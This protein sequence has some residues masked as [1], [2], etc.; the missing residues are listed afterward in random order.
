VR[1]DEFID[2]VGE[3]AGA[4]TTEAVTASNAVL[5]ALGERIGLR[6]AADTASQLPSELQE[7]LLDPDRSR[8]G[9]FGA[10]EFVERVGERAG[11]EEK[12]A[13]DRT[14]AVFVALSEAVSEGE[15]LDWQPGL[16]TD[17]VDLA[18]RPAETGQNP[19]TT[20]PDSPARQG[21][22]IGGQEFIHRVAE[23]A[24]LDDQNAARATD[25]VLETLGERIAAGEGQDLATQLPEPAAA[26]LTRAGGDAQA[27]P[28]AEFVRRIAER[29]GTL[30]VVAREHAR[31]VLTTVREAVTVDEWQDAVEQ[32][33]REYEELLL[34]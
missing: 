24:G 19:R 10:A 11:L 29:E 28:A 15:L 13:L 14:R 20:P 25:V 30:D 22:V 8:S 3:L 33:P 1:Y 32:L 21:P 23:R 5:R 4:S 34:T 7:P 27:M 12:D 18:A 16:Q 26:P 17:Y 31:A 9:P 6:E 2:R